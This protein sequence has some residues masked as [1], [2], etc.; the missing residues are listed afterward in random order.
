MNK[1]NPHVHPRRYKAWKIVN[2]TPFDLGIMGVII[3]N[4]IQMGISFENEPP[5]YTYLLDL[6]NYFFTAIFLIEMLLKMQ[7]YSWRYFETTWNKFD[8]FIV[9]SSLIDI[10]LTWTSDSSNEALSVGP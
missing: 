4:I 6:S 8:C 7:A 2:S 3:L 5:M 9:T 10:L 1:P